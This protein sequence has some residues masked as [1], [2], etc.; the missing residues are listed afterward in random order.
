MV[1]GGRVEERFRPR[2]K[3]AVFISSWLPL[4]GAAFIATFVR[5]IDTRLVIAILV[6]VVSPLPTIRRVRK[7][8]LTV[9]DDGL[10]LQRDRYAL[11]VPWDA[12][13]GVRRCRLQ[14]VMAVDELQLADSTL[15]GRNSRGRNQQISPRVRKHAG[16]RCIHISIYDK[17]WRDGRIGTE[18]RSRGV[19]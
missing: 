7:R 11:R 3:I 17:D 4:L 15:I 8:S 13:S 6:L 2:W 1:E 18:L 14:G 19:L 9:T 5:P 12:V 16:A 10:E